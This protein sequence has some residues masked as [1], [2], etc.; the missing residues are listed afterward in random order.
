LPI[1][2]T[3]KTIIIIIIMAIGLLQMPA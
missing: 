3:F 1:Y 2:W